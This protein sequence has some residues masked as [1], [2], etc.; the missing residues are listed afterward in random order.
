MIRILVLLCY[1]MPNIKVK[2]F[3]GQQTLNIGSFIFDMA[4]IKDSTKV[5]IS[6]SS[7]NTILVY[8]NNG[9]EF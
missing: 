8:N 1:L 7:T 6:E 4:I 9:E 2:D 3:K 5:Y